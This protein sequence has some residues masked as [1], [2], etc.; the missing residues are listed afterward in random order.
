MLTRYSIML[1]LEVGAVALYGL[2]LVFMLGFSLAQWQL[3]WQ[4]ATV[5]LSLPSA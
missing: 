4:G 5:Q 2:C 3:T 1:I